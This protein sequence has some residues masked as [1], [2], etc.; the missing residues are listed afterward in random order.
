MAE[1]NRRVWYGLYVFLSRY[2]SPPP[3]QER[4]LENIS[5]Q[6]VR[7]TTWMREET[8]GNSVSACE[9]ESKTKILRSGEAV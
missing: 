3:Y 5:E 2:S 6:N 1:E 8:T 4:A 7:K 9:N